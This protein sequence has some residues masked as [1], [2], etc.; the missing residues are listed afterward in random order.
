MHVYVLDYSRLEELALSF[1]DMGPGDQ[2]QAIKFGSKHLCQAVLWALK[3]FYVSFC[4]VLE[5]FKDTFLEN[6][7]LYL[8][9]QT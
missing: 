8:K 6:K 5:Y 1:Y 7:L 3:K 9:L 2:T 4:S